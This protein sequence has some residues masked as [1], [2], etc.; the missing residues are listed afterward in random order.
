MS[1]RKSR[2]DEDITA[3]LNSVYPESPKYQYPTRGERAIYRAGMLRAAE[4]CDAL[5]PR[6]YPITGALYDGNC[7]T[8]IRD[9]A[10]AKS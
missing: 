4:I 10:D 6:D 2:M 8:A 7:A 3:A 9:E 5:G 1:E